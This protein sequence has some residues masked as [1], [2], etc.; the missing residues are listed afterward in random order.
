[1]LQTTINA[2]GTIRPASTDPSREEAFLPTH[3]AQAHAAFLLALRNGGLACTWFAGTEEGKPDVSIYFT[4]LPAGSRQWTH[5]IKVSD[6]PERS[7]QNPVLFE[8]P[9]GEL[10]LLYTAQEFGNQDTAIVRR[11]I[12][13]D[14]GLTWGAIETLFDEPG[15]FIRQPM[16]VLSSGEWILPIF[17]CLPVPGESWHGQNDVSAVK[18]STDAGRTWSE[19][20][21]PES[22]GAVHMNIVERRGG[23]LLGLFR[24]R[25]ADSILA[26]TSSD[27]GR[28]WTKPE[29]T[30]LP[31]NNASI[32]CR[33]LA[34]GT[35]ALVFN[36]VAASAA[37]RAQANGGPI[38]G[39]PRTPLSI[40]LS[41]DEGR[42]WPVIRD[43]EVAP[44]NPPELNADKQDRRARELSYPTVAG[45][46]E[47][48]INVA[49]TYF[50]KAIKFVRFDPS[51]VKGA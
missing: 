45:D 40:A 13:R 21:V 4:R 33:A 43:I 44:D 15:T 23:T 5:E 34:D 41:H 7:E 2:D 17:H 36:N 35:F 30:D 51:W 37:V 14:G 11:R 18:I 24:S 6:D 31:N 38:W 3:V 1:M 49:F 28:T 32:Q 29:P 22:L 9:A 20:P 12:S 47:G 39:V 48:R 50:R 42:T 16:V 19:H 26:S 10:W 27:K 25:H 46:A 8:T